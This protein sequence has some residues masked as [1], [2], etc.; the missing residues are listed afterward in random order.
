MVVNL[1]FCLFQA[2][3]RIQ[4]QVSEKSMRKH[5]TSDVIA[6]LTQDEEEEIMRLE[7]KYNVAVRRRAKIDG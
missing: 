5:I 3:K 7:E 2:W 4:D 1:F 6:F